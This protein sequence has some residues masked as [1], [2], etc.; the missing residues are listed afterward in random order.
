MK[1]MLIGA[2]HDLRL[3]GYQDLPLLKTVLGHALA[4]APLEIQME[5]AG[6]RRLQTFPPYDLGFEGN[7]AILLDIVAS[8]I[9]IDPDRGWINPFHEFVE[10]SQDIVQHFRNLAQVNF[11]NTLLRKWVFDTTLT[12]AQVDLSLLTRPLEGSEDHLDDV[13]NRIQWVI[14]SVPLF[15]SGE[16]GAVPLS[17]CARSLRRPGDSWN[18][19]L[20]T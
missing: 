5:K 1:A 2:R 12:V 10:A 6:M 20:A 11:E 8:Q 3:R 18:A 17:S 13:D 16:P 15:F 7:I 14:H 19:T 4:A 9:K